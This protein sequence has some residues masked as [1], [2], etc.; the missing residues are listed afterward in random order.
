LL[1]EKGIRFN[2]PGMLIPLPFRQHIVKVIGDDNVYVS[3]S[4][5]TSLEPSPKLIDNPTS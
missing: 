3:S 1:G 5:G 4:F 2:P